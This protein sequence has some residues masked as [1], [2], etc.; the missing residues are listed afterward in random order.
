MS[1]RPPITKQETD[2]YLSYYQ[3][4]LADVGPFSPPDVTGAQTTSHTTRSGRRREFSL[5][6]HS[7]SSS[8]YSSPG[9]PTRDIPPPS[10]GQVRR[11]P[12]KTS[13]TS[14]DRRR[15]HIVET[16]PAH[17]SGSG[18]RREDRYKSSKKSMHKASSS[19]ALV[20]PPDAAPTTYQDLT[21]PPL[22]AAVQQHMKAGDEQFR[23]HNRSATTHVAE[24]DYEFKKEVRRRGSQQTLPKITYPSQDIVRSLTPASQASSTSGKSSYFID[25]RRS[26][27]KQP[28]PT[29]EIGESKP[30]HAS[31]AAPVITNIDFANYGRGSSEAISIRPSSS[32]SSSHSHVPSPLFSPNQPE[33]YLHY[34]PGRYLFRQFGLPLNNSRIQVY[35]PEL[36]PFRCLPV[37]Q[38]LQVFSPHHLHRD[39][40]LS[41]LRL[42]RAAII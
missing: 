13:R 8:D 37:Q 34:Q 26:K 16:Q 27:D 15:L 9:S 32:T 7:D 6:S 29:P 1:G 2:S 31:V 30:I 42:R 11:R 19:F 18:S 25:I 39:L 20:A 12:S 3:S 28:L 35:T 21:P 5:S 17:S 23:K 22:S 33:D 41:S 24:S 38:V 36:V 4:P 14:G 10:D 40:L